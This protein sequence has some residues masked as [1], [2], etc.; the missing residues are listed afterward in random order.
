MHII[1]IK[2]SDIILIISAKHAELLPPHPG[3]VT[4]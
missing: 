1:V 4:G 2:S 3:E